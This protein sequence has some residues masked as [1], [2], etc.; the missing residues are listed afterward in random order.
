M[1]SNI[2]HV[3]MGWALDYLLPLQLFVCCMLRR[4]NRN[5]MA[6]QATLPL[7][8]HPLNTSTIGNQW[9]RGL[10]RTEPH[11]LAL[12]TALRPAALF[13]P[14][15]NKRLH[16]SSGPFLSISPILPL[17]SCCILTGEF[18]L[19]YLVQTG[20]TNALKAAGKQAELCHS[21]Q[22]NHR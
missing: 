2:W 4:I 13:I 10:A 22:I 16:F 15:T 3:P 20:E 11:T 18:P 19:S 7:T 1:Q 12:I 14:V 6:S 5:K 9:P 21:H 17:S 8:P